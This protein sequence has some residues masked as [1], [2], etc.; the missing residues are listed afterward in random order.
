MVTTIAVNSSKHNDSAVV[1]CR[2]EKRTR[3]NLAAEHAMEQSGL[4]RAANQD[5]QPRARNSPQHYRV[6]LKNTF[7]FPEYEIGE[8]VKP[9]RRASQ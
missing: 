4:P 3:I 2:L 1:L 8:R 5:H 9:A 7:S 6:V